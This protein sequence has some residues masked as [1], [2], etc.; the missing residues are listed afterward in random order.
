MN[1]LSLQGSIA[2]AIQISTGLDD[3]DQKDN[4]VPE[5]NLSASGDTKAKV[6]QCVSDHRIAIL[7]AFLD[8]YV[9]LSARGDFYGLL[10]LNKKVEPL[11]HDFSVLKTKTVYYDVRRMS[12]DQPTEKILQELG[13]EL[14][15]KPIWVPGD[16]SCIYNTASVGACGDLSLVLEIKLTAAYT[17]VKEKTAIEREAQYRGWDVMVDS[18]MDEICKCA[19]PNEWGSM[20]T[21]TAIARGCKFNMQVIYPPVNGLSDNYIQILGGQ[22]PPPHERPARPNSDFTVSN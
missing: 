4:L 11:L 12:V 20:Y 18:Y 5:A 19:T 2:D 6:S 22:F 3:I 8:E 17:L 10:C 1:V 16:G 9:Q 21:M 15:G 14:N 7:T 13:L